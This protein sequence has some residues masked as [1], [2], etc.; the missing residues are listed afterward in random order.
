MTRD[1]K[2]VVVVAT[3]D[4]NQT[5][6]F[7]ST[8][9][10]YAELDWRCVVVWTGRSVQTSTLDLSP[11]ARDVVV[12]RL[13]RGCLLQDHVR[14]GAAETEARHTCDAR[15]AGARSSVFSPSPAAGAWPSLNAANG[16]SSL[17]AQLLPV[18]VLSID[19]MPAC[20]AV[21]TWRRRV[22][23]RGR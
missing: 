7:W 13:W 14:V 5:R 9:R 16:S 2:L 17:I 23:D 11:L 6:E 15:C 20:R 4:P 18:N 8:W 3:A 19:L 1:A 12:A 22:A 10:H 21:T